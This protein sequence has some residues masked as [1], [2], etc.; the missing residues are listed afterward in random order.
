MNQ[1]NQALQASIESDIV[2]VKEALAGCDKSKWLG[3]MESEYASLMKN[4]TWKLT[5]C[6]DGR[7][8]IGCKWVLK[9]KRDEFGN[10]SRYKARLVAQGFSQIPGVDFN[11]TFAPVIK[12][13]SLRMMMAIGLKLGRRIIQMD[14]ETAYLN[15]NLKEQI[16]PN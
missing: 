7:K 8:I 16:L 15:G 13:S 5:Y 10:I 14:V 1:I 3:A 11:E 4:E 12:P 6:P 2:D 9:V